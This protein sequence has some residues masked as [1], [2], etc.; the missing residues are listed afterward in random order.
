MTDVIVIGAGLNGLVAA[1]TL[2]KQKLSVVLLDQRE[3]VG[4]AAVTTEFSPG[5]HAPTLSHSLG[6]VSRDVARALGLDRA[7]ELITPTA[8]LT[9][10]GR[11]GR[12]LVLHR[13]GVLAAA[14]INAFS[15]A[16]AGRWIGSA[17]TRDS[18]IAPVPADLGPAGLPKIACAEIAARKRS[19]SNHS[20]TRSPTGIGIH[21]AS[22]ER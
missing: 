17:A 18:N 3:V 21:R 12:A 7:V 11:D 20:D 15:T 16:D 13:D 5:Y 10:L 9:T 6:P 1:A 2:A 4:G 22:C 8:A 19:V 14:A